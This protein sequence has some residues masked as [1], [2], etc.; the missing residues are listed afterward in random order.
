MAF[1]I[2][3]GQTVLFTGDS[4]TDCGRRGDQRP[5]G[6]GYVRMAVDLINA[7][8]PA[9][10]CCFIN[11]GISG[12]IVSDLFDRWTDD[13]INRKPDWVSI[14][15]GINDIHR[16]L[17]G[18]ADM[19]DVKGYEDYYEKIL[20]RVKKETQAKLV[21][22]T[23]FY[24]SQANPTEADGWRGRVM[25]E[26]PGYIR[27]TEKLAKRYRAKLVHTQ[28]MFKEQFKRHRTDEFG[29]EPVHPDG[30]GHLLIAH[31]WLKTMGW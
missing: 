28:N 13:C 18:N 9:N 12:N 25:S 15:I 16:Y 1:A 7:R 24:M 6:G 11:T 20:A 14:M 26:I 23:P 22:I 2:K 4:I 10:K 27:V 8:Y 3:P 21:L 5:L 17:S 30:H 31:E 19:Y 29:G